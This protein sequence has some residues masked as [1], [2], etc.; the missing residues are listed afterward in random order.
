M[1]TYLFSLIFGALITILPPSQI[2]TKPTQKSHSAP[3]RTLV[4]SV[5]QT[6]PLQMST[7]R[8]IQTVVNENDQVV[9]VQASPLDPTTVLVTG[10]APGRTRITLTDAD[11]KKEVCTIGKSAVDDASR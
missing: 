6:I 2:K 7:K 11:G 8:A 10:V 5:G 1:A 9:R 3:V 4:L